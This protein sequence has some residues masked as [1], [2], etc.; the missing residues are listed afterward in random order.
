MI[1]VTATVTDAA[2]TVSAPKTATATI[3]PAISYSTYDIARGIDATEAAMRASIGF[4][5]GSLNGH[6]RA[7]SG[8]SHPLTFAASKVANAANWNNAAVL[9]TKFPDWEALANGAYDGVISGFYNSWPIGIRGWV[10]CNHEPENDAG[11]AF[12]WITGIRRYIKVA[13]ARI[14]ARGLNV[15]VGGVLMSYSW[16]SERWQ[17]YQWWIDLPVID[18]PQTFFGLD[19]YGRCL[20]T[21]PVTGEDLITPLKAIIAPVRTEGINRFALFETGLDRRRKGASTIIGTD[22]TIANWLPGFESG[23]RS[24]PG[25]EVVSMFYSGQVGPAAQYAQINGPAIPA[26]AS[27]VSRGQR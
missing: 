22:Q 9:N 10:T 18:R 20:P 8:A 25:M 7:Y 26:W 15:A 24:I 14:R 2:G 3:G 1:S 4:T 16:D 12:T 17:D 6:Q 21:T 19:H 23:L 13:A 5:G 27:I 11:D